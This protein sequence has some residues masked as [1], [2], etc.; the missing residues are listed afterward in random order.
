MLQSNFNPELPTKFYIGGWGDDGSACHTVRNGMHWWWSSYWKLFIVTFLTN[1][2]IFISGRLEFF[3]HIL[4]GL[5]LRRNEYPRSPQHHTKGRRAPWVT[6]LL[7]IAVYLNY[8]NKIEIFIGKQKL[9]FI[10]FR[11]LNRAFIDFLID[12]G[13][14]LSSFHLIGHSAGAH[15]VGAA[16]ASV[17]H[18]KVPR[19]T[20]S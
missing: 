5:Y 11:L 16:G 12:N 14:P 15:L 1:D 8:R 19:V 7:L 3:Y 2:R 10:S 20:G 6:N 17:T 13:A 9:K 18:G 4:V